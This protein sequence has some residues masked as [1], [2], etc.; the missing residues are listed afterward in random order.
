[1]KGTDAM[2]AI[3]ERLK[4]KRSELGYTLAFV[5]NKLGQTEATTQR[6]E[7]G[8]IKTIPYNK[9]YEYS[10]LYRTTPA[11]LLG[12]EGKQKMTIEQRVEV[13][14]KIARL[15]A[16]SKATFYDLEKIEFNVRLYLGFTFSDDDKLSDIE[17]ASK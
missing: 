9:I 14:K 15:I 7:S 11:Y 13:A 1:M 8:A 17:T 5:A 16:E 10:K 6:H 4:A 12:W 3:N 2:D